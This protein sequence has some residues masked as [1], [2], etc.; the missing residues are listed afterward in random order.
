GQNDP[1]LGSVAVTLGGL[2]NRTVTTW[3]GDVDIDDSGV[4]TSVSSLVRASG[5][6]VGSY[7]ITSASFA[8]LSNYNAPVYT[9]G[10]AQ[11]NISK[12]NLTASL[13]NQSKVYGATDRSLGSVA[14]TLV[15][16]INRTV[17]TWMG[18]VNIDDSGVTT[19]V[20]SLARA[21][22]EN[23]GS[24]N[25]TSA[26][27]AALSNYNAPVYTSGSAQ[28]NITKANLTASL[29]NQSK[30]YGD[31]DP[32][33]GRG[34]V[35]LG[36][37]INRTVTTWMGDVDIDDS[38]VTTSV[39]SLAR[40]SGENVGSYNI[41]SASFAALS[42]YN[43]P[44]YTSGSAQL[45]ITKA[46]LTASLANQ[47]KVYGANDPSLNS[48][49]V[50]LGGL[51]NRTVTTW[52]GDV[53]IDD[54]AV[55]TSVSSLVRASGENVGSCNIT[56]ASFAALSNYNAPVY[57]SGSAQLNITKANLT[58]SLANQSKVYGANDPS[59]GSVAVTL[60]GLINRTVTTWM[61]DVDI[62]DSGVTTSVSSLVRA[63]GENVGSYNITSAS[64][65]ALSNYNA[66]VYTSGS[67]QLNITKANLTASLANQSKVYGAN[68]PSLGSV[69]VTLGGLINRT[70]TTWMGDVDID[71]SG[72]TTSVSSLVRASGE[73]VG[74]YNITSA[75]C[76]ALSNY[77]APVYTSGSAQLNITKANL[78]ASLAN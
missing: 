19:S 75:S 77:N 73:N 44:V 28:L 57:T 32:S 15:G 21:S 62:D 67:A 34:G 72:V 7:N 65:A 22:G 23:V 24:Y 25:I 8:A 3:M 45:N 2:I 49:A 38:G 5:E 12:A 78:T 76:A 69:A 17:T 26:S 68:D 53:D 14:V 40:A 42:N 16:L 66:P 43:A 27:F 41:T 20:S 61:G 35:T 47:S 30:V 33:L 48:V 13:A 71:D 10:S 46:N 31:N 58:A 18:D 64:C 74:S 9:S 50:T 56:S 70:V 11:L 55:T 59:L 60:G 4:T 6:N 36:G 1:S 29:A 51:I 52:M 37:L 63:S 39:S 54:S